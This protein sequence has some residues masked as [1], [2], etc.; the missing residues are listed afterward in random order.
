[1]VHQYLS[2]YALGATPE[3]LQ[4]I[5][6]AH[7]SFQRPLPP[8]SK[9][10]ELTRDNY[11]EHLGNRDWYPSYLELFKKEIDELGVEKAVQYWIFKDDMLPRFVGAAIHPLIHMG[12]A[13]EFD[14]PYVAAEALASTACAQG[15]LAPLMVEESNNADPVEHSLLDLVEKIRMDPDLYGVAK[16]SDEAKL[17]NVVH[18]DTAVQK[19]REAVVLWNVNGEWCDLCMNAT[20]NNLT[21]DDV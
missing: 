6:D 3:R 19:I 2:A 8:H 10:V 5:F 12:Y 7:A 18:S 1:M 11:R 15:Y 13:A 17:M 9:V 14:I 20:T 16:Y 21:Y 4:E